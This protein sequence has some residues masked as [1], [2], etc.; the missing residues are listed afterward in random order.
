MLTGLV[1]VVSAL[2]EFVERHRHP[3]DRT[4]DPGVPPHVTVLFPWV[5]QPLNDDMLGRCAAAVRG[6]GPLSMHFRRVATFPI[7]VVYLVPEPEAPLR[8]L[9]RLL[10]DAYPQCPP[11]AGEHPDPEPHLTISTVPPQDLADLAARVAADLTPTRC[12]V[13]VL[14]VL[15]QRPDGRWRTARALPLTD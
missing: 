11:Y 15:E 13:D 1:L 8:A 10:S 12:T 7:G 5:R 14:T 9:T 2:D 4:G 6:F 3:S